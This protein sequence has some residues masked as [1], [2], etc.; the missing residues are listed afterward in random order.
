MLN[1]LLNN[2]FKRNVCLLLVVVF[3]STLPTGSTA[4]AFCLD[5]QESHLVEKNFHLVD[6][7]SASGPGWFF[8]DGHFSALAQKEQNDCTDISLTN[9]NILNRPSRTTLPISAKVELSHLFPGG[10]YPQKITGH[11]LSSPSQPIFTLT[12]INIHRTVVLLI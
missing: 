8:S 12:H 10:I 7:H 6:C 1:I 4:M 2:L 5:D 9:A 3:L 11:S